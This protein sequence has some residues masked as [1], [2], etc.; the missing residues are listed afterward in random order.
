MQNSYAHYLSFCYCAQQDATIPEQPLPSLQRQAILTILILHAVLHHLK[1]QLADSSQDGVRD[2]LVAAVQH[3]HC[4]LPQQPLNPL[5]KGLALG[6]RA[7]QVGKQLRAKAGDRRECHLRA[8][9]TG[10]DMTKSTFVQAA[11]GW[12]GMVVGTTPIYS[13]HALRTSP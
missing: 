2:V 1:L 12:V 13:R 4:A 6:G 9:R 8:C 11:A 10:Q 7:A 3:L 5:G